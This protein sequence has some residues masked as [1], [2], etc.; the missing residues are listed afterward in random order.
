MVN[1]ITFLRMSLNA[2]YSFFS[3]FGKWKTF[4]VFPFWNRNTSGNLGERKMEVGKTSLRMKEENSKN[5]QDLVTLNRLRLC[6]QVI[7]RI[8]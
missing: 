2:K 5:L 7:N 3:D 4:F 6:E 1:P 8:A